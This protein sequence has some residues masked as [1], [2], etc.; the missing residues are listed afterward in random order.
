[1]LV[2]QHAK[3]CNHGE[4]GAVAGSCLFTE[5]GQAVAQVYLV[6]NILSTKSRNSLIL[7][8]LCTS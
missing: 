5:D 4:L 7:Y 8:Y 1:M 3:G 2:V 6:V